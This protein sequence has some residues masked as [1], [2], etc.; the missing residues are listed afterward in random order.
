MAKSHSDL[1]ITTNV[2]TDGLGLPGRL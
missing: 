1:C 2:V